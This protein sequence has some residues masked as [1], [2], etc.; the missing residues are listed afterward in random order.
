MFKLSVRRLIFSICQYVSLINFITLSKKISLN[1]F[2]VYLLIC[3]VAHERSLL[4]ASGG[5]VRSASTMT[6]TC[7]PPQEE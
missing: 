2:I 6:A 1:A 7:T 5:A 4:F 3:I